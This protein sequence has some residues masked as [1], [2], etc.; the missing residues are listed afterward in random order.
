MRHSVGRSLLLLVAVALVIGVE[1]SPDAAGR[2][3]PSSPRCSEAQALENLG[4]LDAAEAAYLRE[5]GSAASVACAEQGLR[6][7]GRRAGSC[8]NAAALER[9]GE[10]QNAHAAYL[11]V[12]GVD[13]S[14]ACANAGVMR[15][16]P[17]TSVSGWFSTAT[18]T[19]GELLGIVVLGLLVLA[20]IGVSLLQVE[21]RLPR[22]RDWWPSKDIRRPTLEIEALKDDALEKR[23]GGS[24]AGLIRGQVTWKTDRFGMNLVSGQAGVASA[25]TG[26]GDVSSEAQAAVAVINF[27][28]ATLPRRRFLISGQLQPAG[29]E[30]VGISLE[31][32][33]NGG[34][35]ALISFWGSSLGPGDDHDQGAD[36][37]Q[38]AS[39]YQRLATASAAWVD[40]W[41]VK[42]LG[43]KAMLTAD[44][45]SWAFF[46]SGCEA[47]RLGDSDRAL[48]L[49]EQALAKDGA[50][51]G[52]LANLGILCRRSKRYEDAEEYLNRALPA[53][54]N[55]KLEV[56][57]RLR[58]EHNPDWYRIKYQFA[59]LYTNW[60][61][62]TA[63]AD[64]RA[65]LAQ[66]GA[67]AARSLAQTVLDTLSQP[68]KASRED[69][70]SPE[71]LQHTLKPC[72]EGTIE[73]SI[74]ALVASTAKPIPPR[75]VDWPRPR[76]EFEAIHAAVVADGPID[77]WLLISYIEQGVSRPPALLFNLACFYTRIGDL[78]TAAKRLMASVR[79]TEHPDR[80]A[81]VEVAETDPALKPLR[82]KRPGIIAKLEAMA[83]MDQ[84][85]AAKKLI[86][87]FERQ[88]RVHNRLTA[89]GWT[90]EWEAVGSRFDLRASRDG[91]VLLVELV[92]FEGLTDERVN[93]T[94]GVRTKFLS[95]YEG[96]D[97]VQVW[98]ILPE[99]G[100]KPEADLESAKQQKV[101]VFR[102]SPEG[103]RPVG[104][105][106]AE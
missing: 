95:S 10:R 41:I 80:K 77:P 73:P 69:E 24:I 42:A 49:Y 29:A 106:V 28:T 72:L 99:E 16:A 84:Q 13:P 31:L 56:L 61:L 55:E 50:N 58:R 15:T 67:T 96:R 86:E 43:G 64:E 27:L 97:N 51:V 2:T 82:M 20:I 48:V 90:V 37:D 57:P 78:A 6:R 91:H 44:P 98:I 87:Q 53:T 52:A 34:A 88:G 60:A 81:L 93:A 59:A 83:G 63:D 65:E 101:E 62:D 19:V 23:L 102:D 21:S 39:Q 30:G 94:I 70:A 22:L 89:M 36:Q 68:L 4:L 9:D 103:L 12:L 47:Q 79:E 7:L 105:P 100:P 26:I 40:I 35:E 25:L 32:S 74:L 92:G 5:L 18:T 8:A 38:D 76:P 104:R 66:R 33:Q 85:E 11:K 3:A 71:Y 75:P 46:R 1:A 54:E 45:Q 14:S 17:S